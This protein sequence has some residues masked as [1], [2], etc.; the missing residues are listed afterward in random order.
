[1]TFRSCLAYRFLQTGITKLFYSLFTFESCLALPILADR[2]YYSNNGVAAVGGNSGG[3]LLAAFARVESIERQP[4]STEQRDGVALE[5]Q[6]PDL[7]YV[8]LE[9]KDKLLI[10]AD[11]VYKA[12]LEEWDRRETYLGKRVDRREKT[13]A[14]LR[15]QVFNIVGFFSVF[16]GVVLTAVSQLK[17][18]TGPHCGTVWFP[19]VLSLAA[20]LVAGIGVWLKFTDLEGL[21]L[22]ISNEKQALRVSVLSTWLV[23]ILIL[24]F[25]SSSIFYMPSFVSV[26]LLFLQENFCS[27]H[28]YILLKTKSVCDFGLLD[29]A[30]EV[31][32]RAAKLRSHGLK[33][34]FHTHVKEP[35]LR[36]PKAIWIRKYSVLAALSVFTGIFV[37]S[38]FVILCDRLVI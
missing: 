1:L 21:E 30:Q 12:T 4:T 19:V 9:I 16:Q 27:L 36:E 2:K 8:Y 37:A 13:S 35:M 17:S 20:L 28:L 18:S 26:K 5:V 23:R 32:G 33:F 31:A 6:H 25:L 15:N 14:D 3:D 7:H 11:P 29:D 24:Y 22:S 38:Y 10:E 34:R